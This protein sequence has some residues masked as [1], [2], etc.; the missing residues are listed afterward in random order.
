M[1]QEAE[2]QRSEMTCPRPRGR[3]VVDRTALDT[4]ARL[5][6]ID[7]EMETSQGCHQRR[8]RG[9]NTVRL[10]DQMVGVDM[11]EGAPSF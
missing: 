1:A 2:A 7:R 3:C 11:G 8:E 4:R 6:T 5:V 9:G 10:M